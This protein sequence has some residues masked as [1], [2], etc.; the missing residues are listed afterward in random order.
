MSFMIKNSRNLLVV[1][2]LW[3]LISIVSLQSI[4][5]QD[6]INY[7]EFRDSQKSFTCSK[8][9]LESVNISLKNLLS[10]DTSVITTGLADYFYDLGMAY[11]VKSEMYS[12]SHFRPSCIQSFESCIKKDKKRGSAYHNLSVI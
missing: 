7:L 6:K 8:N 1:K 9:D 11:Y 3:I 10:L 4:N 12:E 5:A 2:Y